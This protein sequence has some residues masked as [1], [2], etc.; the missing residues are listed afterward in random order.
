[1]KELLKN[2]FATG[3][4]GIALLL[5]RLAAGGMMLTHGWA[6]LSNYT[7][8]SETFMDPV[9]W[10]PGP[11]LMLIIFAEFFCSI[12]IILGL[13]TRLAAIPLVIG[14]FVAAFVAHQPF[15]ISG[16]ELPLLYLVVFMALLIAG[17]GRYSVDAIIYRRLDAR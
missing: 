13:L 1:M 2:I 14:M 6:K 11:S 8:L 5:L 16:S 7:E 9:G 3:G 12:A 10:G 17:P 15:S 4:S